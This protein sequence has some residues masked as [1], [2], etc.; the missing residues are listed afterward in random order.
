MLTIV[1]V[2]RI[3]QKGCWLE[4][5][6]FYLQA[7][8]NWTKFLEGTGVHLMSSQP[9]NVHSQERCQ[10]IAAVVKATI[11]QNLPT[12][13]QLLKQ[14]ISIIPATLPDSVRSQTVSSLFIQISRELEKFLKRPNHPI[15][16]WFIVYVGLGA[17]PPEAIQ[18]VQLVLDEGFK[19][20]EDFFVDRQGIHFYADGAASDKMI[21]IPPRLSEFTQMTVRLDSSEVNHVIERFN[22]SEVEARNVVLNL[23]ILEQKM[24]VP[25]E[26]LL[27]VLDD[28]NELLRQVIASDLTQSDRKNSFGL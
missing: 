27:S 19:P 23:K 16:A 10:L 9:S 18:A 6:D 28:N 24:K 8:I 14:V 20:F 1:G 11:S 7:Q 12:L 21:K 5:I 22:L 15:M 17:S 13:D 3:Y 25:I 26:Q 4:G 2:P